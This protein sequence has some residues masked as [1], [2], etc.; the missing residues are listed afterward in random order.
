MLENFVNIT[1][2]ISLPDLKEYYWR[3]DKV[4]D[5]LFA[6]H[7]EGCFLLLPETALDH[8]LLHMHSTSALSAHVQA[9]Q[10][11][12]SILRGPSELNAAINFQLLHIFPNV[13][14]CVC[15]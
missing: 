12:Q 5:S 14:S 4:T 15:I 2:A 1:G 6:C 7:L 11:K 13:A 10:Y 3:S 8:D 9:W